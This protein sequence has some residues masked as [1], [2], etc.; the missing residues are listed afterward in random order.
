MKKQTIII[1]HIIFF[2]GW[3]LPCWAETIVHAA[4]VR[5]VPVV[6]GRDTDAVW[7]EAQEVITR[8]QV[9]GID[10]RIKAVYTDETLSFLIRFPD[11]DES[12]LHKPWLWNREKKMYEIGPQR[13]DCFVLK[14]AMDQETKNLSVFS[15]DPHT[16]DIWFWKAERTDPAGFADDKIDSLVTT[17]EPKAAQLTS[18]TGKIMYLLRM[19]DSGEAA[20][21]SVME[22]DYKGEMISQ[23]ASQLPSGSRADVKAKGEWS[24]QTWTV[25]FSRSLNTGQS[26]DVQFDTSATFLFGISRQEIGGRKPDMATTQPLYGAGDVSE[27]LILAFDR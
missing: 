25:E 19:G 17:A 9:T 11:P 7:N 15:D 20:Y 6:D 18:G 12:R 10:I 26:D 23:F 8:D 4:K 13:E 21:K 22:L 1:G 14:W 2:F 24:D 16:A 27:K 3:Y 5:S